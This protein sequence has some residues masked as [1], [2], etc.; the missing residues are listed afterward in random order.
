MIYQNLINT[1]KSLCSEFYDLDKPVAPKGVLDFYINEIKRSDQPVLEPMCG[2]GRFLIPILE[3]GIDI[4]GADASSEMLLRCK[5]NSQNKNLNPV[6]YNQKIQDF[7]LPE[8]YGLIFIPSGSIGLITEEEEVKQCL[9]SLYSSLK[10]RGKIL[11][12]FET[13]VGISGDG[14]FENREVICR[15]HSVINLTTT[16]DFDFEKNIETIKC[17][18]NKI[19]DSTVTLTEVEH[20]KIKYHHENEF[21][22]LM[23]VGGFTEIEKLNIQSPEVPENNVLFRG[24]KV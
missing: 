1:Y 10:K 24:V 20:L 16:S 6:L 9:R 2:T 11:I 14:S 18:Y 17:E 19:T 15:D 23:E 21:K 7:K 8:K 12:E 4:E 13:P 22:E 3:Q 5:Q